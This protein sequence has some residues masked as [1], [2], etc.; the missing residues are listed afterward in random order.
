MAH[1]P[2]FTDI[3]GKTVFLVGNDPKKGEILRSFG[4][5]V[6]QLE[7]LTEADLEKDPAL[8]VLA[9]GDRREA[10]ELCRSRNIPVNAVDDPENCSFFFP[11]L[12]RR[13][14]ITIAIS[15][16]GKAPAASK[17]LRQRLEQSLP[18]DLE[19]ILSWLGELTIRLRRQ[20]PD[21]GT[22]AALLSQITH[23]AFDLG[24]PL[25]EEE[26]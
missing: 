2:F 23:K 14:D 16:G 22:R 8:V 3:T 6:R 15:S 12:I 19:P 17:A 10:A 13:G 4:A 9:E 24:R 25:T 20:I 11:S 5:N 21:Y 18:E 7:K 26:W 1:F